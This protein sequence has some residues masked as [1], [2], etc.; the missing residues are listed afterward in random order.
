[1]F[2]LLLALLALLALLCLFSV[3]Y[4]LTLL[5]AALRRR[6]PLP[7]SDKSPRI[8]VVIPAHDEELV[9][10]QTLQS[11]RAQNYPAERFEIVVVADNCTDAT[12]RIARSEGATVLE[13]RNLQERGK[14]YALAWAF[15]LLLGPDTPLREGAT[16]AAFAI[17][18]ADTWVA[19]DFLSAMARRLP[20][21]PETLQALQGRYGVL[22]PDSG[23]RAALMHAAFEL[24]NHVKLQGN[25]RLGLPVGLKGNGM[26]FTRATLS[27]APWSG[28]S[29]TEDID[30]GLDL[31][32]EHGLRVQYAPEAL[33]LAQMPVTGAQGASQRARWEGGRYRLVRERVPRLLQAALRRRDLRLLAA[34][35]DLTIPPLAELVGLILLWGATLA[36]ASNFLPAGPLRAH[37]LLLA[38]AFAGLSAYVL[39]GM[40]AAGAGKEA[41][42]ALLRAPLYVLWK[43]ALYARPLLSGGRARRNSARVAEEEWVRTERIPIRVEEG[44]PVKGT[45]S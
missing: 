6:M 2:G 31:L 4:L 23:W 1:M 21:H 28:R 44:D 38:A 10:A 24:C 15:D 40:R 33:V 11:L 35:A 37:A 12:A 22:N 45:H 5:A 3:G 19:P 29:I 13:R 27:Q 43:F 25:D 39:V 14:G 30:Y 42:L 18:D 9:L 7:P 41:Y 20:D 26:V 32:A 8:A 16:V 36:L 34:A 17:V